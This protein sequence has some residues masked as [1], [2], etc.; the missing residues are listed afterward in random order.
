[1]YPY[2]D[3][4]ILIKQKESDSFPEFTAF[5]LKAVRMS[6]KADGH[7]LWFRAQNTLKAMHI[8]LQNTMQILTNRK[9]HSSVSSLSIV[10]SIPS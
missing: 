3:T 6:L 2:I 8:T 9:G 5:Q 7:M 4:H 1:M 10:F